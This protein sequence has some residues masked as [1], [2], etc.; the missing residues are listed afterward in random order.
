MLIRS[1][2]DYSMSGVQKSSRASSAAADDVR[3]QLETEL[4]DTADRLRRIELVSPADAES[5]LGRQSGCDVLDEAE[6]NTT[7]EA[8]F[9]SRERL[10]ARIKRQTLRPKCSRP[11]ARVGSTPNEPPRTPDLAPQRDR[12]PEFDPDLGP[13][14]RAPVGAQHH[15]Q[16]A[17]DA[18]PGMPEA[19]VDAVHFPFGPRGSAQASAQI[20]P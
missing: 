10:L 7:R 14:L 15:A 17:V 3:R 13:R 19:G 12:L 11:S 5:S 1:V 6:A 9:A 2:C 20:V 16:G 18:E 8:L 4:N